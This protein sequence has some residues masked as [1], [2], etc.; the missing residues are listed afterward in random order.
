MNSVSVVVPTYNSERVLSECLESL[1][2]QDVPPSEVIVSDGGS[3]DRTVEIAHQFG[4]TVVEMEANR[5]AQRNAGA[6]IASGKYLLFIDSDMCVT[7]R[8]V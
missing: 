6:Q 7:P 2:L 3:T 4:A 8:V 5:S 1:H